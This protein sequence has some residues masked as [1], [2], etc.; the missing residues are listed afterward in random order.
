MTRTTTLAAIAALTTAGLAGAQVIDGTVDASYGS[1][2]AVQSVQTGFGDAGPSSGGSEL[3][4]AYAQII[5][6]RL[7]VALTGNLENNFNKLD[8]FIDSVAGGENVL[9]ATPDYDFGNSSSNLGGL[10]FDAG[11]TADY[12]LFTRSGGGAYEVDFVDRAGG[13]SAMVAYNSATGNGDGTLTTL[14]TVTA[15]DLGGN[16]SGSALTGV[17]EY[18]FDNTNAAGVAGGSGA[19]DQ[20]AAAAVTTGFEFSIDLA[21]L[22]NP[23]A[24]DIINIAAAVNNGDH[25]YLSN[26]VL[27]GLPA[28]TGNLGGDGSGGFTGDLSGVDF[29]QF[30]GD[31]FFSITVPGVVPEPTSLA[32]LGLGGLGLVRRRK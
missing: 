27:G 14:S 3:D 15:A 21:D 29:N 10:T 30:A 18:A 5:G 2:L 11:F 17:L 19:A 31:Q 8:I 25:N 7:Y 28:D 4:A 12:H 32:L 23:V 22:G 13:T 24:G 20:S 6:N 16:A 9:S 1:P 26:Q